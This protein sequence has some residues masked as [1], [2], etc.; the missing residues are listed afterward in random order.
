MHN[1]F[2]LWCLKFRDIKQG[3]FSYLSSTAEVPKRRN[4]PS[5]LSGIGWIP[6]PSLLVS[7][8]LSLGSD[9]TQ[10]GFGRK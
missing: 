1:L 7:P 2:C 4:R 8:E 3:D 10:P 6:S 9:Q 5:V